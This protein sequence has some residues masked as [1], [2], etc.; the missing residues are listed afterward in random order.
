MNRQ[1]GVTLVEMMIG[2][3]IVAIT[4][5]M[6]VPAFSQWIQ[7]AQNRTAAESVLNG[8]QLARAEAIKR[9]ALVRF[10]LTDATGLVAW[11]VGCVIVTSDCPAMI[12]RRAGEEGGS[13][14]RTGVSTDALASPAPATQFSTAIAP[15]SGLPAGVSFDALGRAPD[16]N[17]GVDVTRI[18]ITSATS[19][20]A[21]R[22]VVFVG[23]SGQ[24]R[25]CDPALP[26]AS[27]P[28]GCS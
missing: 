9:N 4:L 10:N 22:Y 16:V 24:I 19:S 23:P 25:M 2:I 1:R 18:D 15:G 13:G 3:A 28:Q 12:Q 17:T 26:F 5:A 27:N 6:G 7:T 21:R 14:A 20:E 11:N 8:L